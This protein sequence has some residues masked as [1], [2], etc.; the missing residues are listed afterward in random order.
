MRRI[1]IVLLGLWTA[2]LLLGLQGKSN[3]AQVLGVTKDEILIGA[4]AP[5]TGPNMANGVACHDGAQTYFDMINAAGGVNGRKLKVIWEDDGCVPTKG[6]AATRKLTERDGVFALFG[7]VCSNAL[8]DSI[9]NVEKAKVPWLTAS[10]SGPVITKPVKPF[11]F[12]A[13]TNPTDVQA[14]I[15]V[16][17]AVEFYRAKNLGIL[18]MSDEYGSYFRDTFKK[19]LDENK[20]RAAATETS[21]PGDVDFTAQLAR[22][23][24]AKAD[25]VIMIM[26]TPDAAVMIKQA[27]KMDF[28]PLWIGA[29]PTGSGPFPDLAGDAAIGTVHAWFFKYLLTDTH[30]PMVAK[31]REEFKKRIGEKPGRPNGDDLISYNGAM[32]FVEGLKRA[33]KDLTREKLIKSLESIKNF[34]TFLPTPVTFSPTE[35]QGNYGL[36]FIV[37]L[38]ELRQ[39]I[40]DVHIKP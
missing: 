32:V 25:V 37:D 19:Y 34:E 40:L 39:S 13:G 8:V 24:E 31:F 10:C 23:K 7:G 9:P 12:R 29:L 20:M 3:A 5:L 38:P 17:A 1:G 14:R 11:L 35:H 36:G 15:L 30:V 21:N 4:L 16:K 27:K 2:F 33:G 28:N 18:H 6:I 22:L 26:W